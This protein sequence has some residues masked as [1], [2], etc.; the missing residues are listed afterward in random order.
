M[1][2]TSAGWRNTPTDKS[3]AAQQ[4]VFNVL[5]AHFPAVCISEYYLSVKY[6][7]NTIK[8]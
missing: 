5:L 6:A 7:W 8:F 3:L 1:D 2:F 4:R